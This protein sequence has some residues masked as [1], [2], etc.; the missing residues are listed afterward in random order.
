MALLRDCMAPLRD[1][2]AP[3]RG[4]MALLRGLQ[5]APTWVHDALAWVH[6]LGQS[7]FRPLCDMLPQCLNGLVERTWQSVL[8][9][10]LVC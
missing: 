9:G 8:L 1:C 7:L 3:L 6:D 5:G 2:M 10:F 4:C